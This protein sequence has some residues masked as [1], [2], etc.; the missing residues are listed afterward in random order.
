MGQNA[1]SN[2]VK[3]YLAA[4]IQP[5]DLPKWLPIVLALLMIGGAWAQIVGKLDD[6]NAAL[7]ESVKR[8]E[9]MER[10]LSSKDPEYWE[11]AKRLEP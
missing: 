4:P 10:Y 11:T 2:G 7:Q 1:E 3:Q 8:G 5:G 6:Q 9:R